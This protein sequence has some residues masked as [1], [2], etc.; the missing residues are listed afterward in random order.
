MRVRNQRFEGF[1]IDFMSSESSD[2]DSEKMIGHHPLWHSLS[3]FKLNNKLS[4]DYIIV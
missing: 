4:Y 3:T 2:S 1:S